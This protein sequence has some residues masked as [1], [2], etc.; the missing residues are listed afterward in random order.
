MKKKIAIIVG[1]IFSFFV[2]ACICLVVYYNSCLE[3][4]VT[5][6]NDIKQ[7]D[8]VVEQGSTTN[9]IIDSLYSKKLIK[10]KYA[11]YVFV[12]LN[13]DYVM[14]AGNYELNNGMSLEEI[15]TKINNGEVVDNSI[16]VT[17][18]EGKRI[19]NYV[20]VINKNTAKI[21]LRLAESRSSCHS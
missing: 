13:N 18:V 8:F 15:L 5:N 20:K 16:T 1:A 12:K 14:Q 6:K 3:S 4:V 9:Q 19:T 7:I 17:F 2:I 10:N 11:A 21:I